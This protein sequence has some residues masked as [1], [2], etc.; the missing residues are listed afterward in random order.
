MTG[1]PSEA[2]AGD[3]P[4]NALTG[5]GCTEEELTALRAHAYR[6]GLQLQAGCRTGPGHFLADR[7]ASVLASIIAN[8]AG[9]AERAGAAGETFVA[10]T[11]TLLG[12]LRAQTRAGAGEF[13]DGRTLD[14]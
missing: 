1:K 14:Q 6:L 4:F 5:A 12:M 8:I 11:L 10:R 9:N 3:R 2:R 13:V 7:A